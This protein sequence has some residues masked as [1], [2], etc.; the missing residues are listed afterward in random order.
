MLRFCV[1][2]YH[3]GLS[4]CPTDYASIHDGR[5]VLSDTRRNVPGLGGGPGDSGSTETKGPWPIAP[6]DDD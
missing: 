2:G 1:I 4:G 6:D 5:A 3:T